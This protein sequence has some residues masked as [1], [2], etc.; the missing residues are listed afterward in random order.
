[1]SFS[2][3]NKI[4]LR[5]NI[6]RYTEADWTDGE[7]TEPKLIPER[8]FPASWRNENRWDAIPKEIKYKNQRNKNSNE[9]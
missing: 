7:R 1:V 5:R 4:R 2:I 9:F 6:I 3:Y 8:L